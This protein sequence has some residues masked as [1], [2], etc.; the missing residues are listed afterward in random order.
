MHQA[1]NIVNGIPQLNNGCIINE[2]CFEI[3]SQAYPIGFPLILSFVYAIFG[4]NIPAFITLQTFILFL[5]G[6][7]WF[8]TF[9]KRMGNVLA[10]IGVFFIVYSPYVIW[11]RNNILS[12]FSYILFQSLF[13][14]IYIFGKRRKYWWLL[15]LLYGF[16]W[17]MRGG[18][19]QL[20]VCVMLFE[21]V[22]LLRY[23]KSPSFLRLAKLKIRLLLGVFSIGLIVNLFLNKLLFN[24][25]D[26]FSFYMKIYNEKFNLDLSLI[27][28]KYYLNEIY[29]SFFVYWQ[30]GWLGFLGA[31][32]FLY[33]LIIGFKKLVGRENVLL[34]VLVIQF[35]SIIAFPFQ[36]GMRY[37]L[38]IIPLIVYIM[39]KGVKVSFPSNTLLKL[40]I[41]VIFGG[42]VF[43]Q[44][45]AIKNFNEHVSESIIWTPYSYPTAL[46][47]Q[48]I[49]QNTPSDAV[50]V[51][52]FPRILSFFTERSAYNPCVL[53]NEEIKSDINKKNA[54]YVVLNKQTEKWVPTLE[55]FVESKII[56]LDTVYSNVEVVIL[57]IKK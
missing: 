18:G 36:Q 24:T 26:S 53:N 31:L 15:G 10:I 30:I 42:F 16:S 47:W 23:T 3:S 49:K 35:I 37:V 9:R 56:E 32:V 29:Y 8:F 14:F 57:K 50:F 25:G 55:P 51:T 1:R 20:I 12:E 43:S 27:N 7:T 44:V 13:L 5:L 33:F 46:G 40:T 28:F 34:Y 54:T 39:L 38:P 45:K 4:E 19:V 17:I 6:M 2:A 52:A 22:T 41:F 11:F 48:Y 21:L